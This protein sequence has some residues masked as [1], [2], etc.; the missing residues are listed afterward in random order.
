MSIHM[1]KAY[2]SIGVFRKNMKLGIML[3]GLWEGPGI[4]Q[5]GKVS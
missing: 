5:V 4:E 3:I 1:V 2:S